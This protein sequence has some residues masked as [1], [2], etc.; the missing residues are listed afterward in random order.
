MKTYFEGSWSRFQGNLGAQINFQSSVS[1]WVAQALFGSRSPGGS[2]TYKPTMLNC[3][4]VGRATQVGRSAS[5]W[6]AQP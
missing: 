6:V 4:C 3:L 1:V 5:T 2:R